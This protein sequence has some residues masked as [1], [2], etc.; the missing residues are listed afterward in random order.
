MHSNKKECTD[1]SRN[2]VQLY[3]DVYQC[4]KFEVYRV[5]FFSNNYVAQGQG[6]WH[7]DWHTDRPAFAKQYVKQAFVRGA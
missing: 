1:L 3:I 5:K 6:D 2:R 4:T 7:T